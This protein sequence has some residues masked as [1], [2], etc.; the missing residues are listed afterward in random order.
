MMEP[1]SSKPL[2][3]GRLEAMIEAVEPAARLVERRWLRRI[4]R[5]HREMPVAAGPAPHELAYWI[6]REELLALVTP[7]ELGLTTERVPQGFV[8]LLPAPD[9]EELTPQTTSLTLRRYQ[10]AI[11]HARLDRDIDRGFADGFLTDAT[12]RNCFAQLGPTTLHEIR[13]LLDEEELLFN[14]EDDRSLYREFVAYFFSL[15]S[16]EPERLRDFLPGLWDPEATARE[17]Q[18]HIDAAAILDATRFPEAILRAQPAEAGIVPQQGSDTSAA[19]RDRQRWIRRA[20]DAARRG[21][22]VRAAFYYLRAG[23]PASAEERLDHLVERLQAALQLEDPARWRHALRPLLDR[24]AA[25]DWPV[26]ARLLYDL[27]KACIDSERPLYAVDVIEWAV[28]LGKKPIQRRLDRAREINLLRHL[29]AAARHIGGLPLR[30]EQQ[31]HLEALLHEEI[32]AAEHRARSELSPI[33]H[34]VLDDVGLR[35]TNLPEEI[36][37]NKATEE[38]LDQAC[39]RGFL[40]M[41]D[42][43]DALARNRL[44]LPDLSGPVEWLRGDPLIRA[45]RLLALR[46]D[47]VYHRGEI[48]LRWL[49]R[50]SALAF[51]TRVG[52]FVTRYLALPFGGAFVVLEGV[53]HLYHAAVGAAHFFTGRTAALRA[54]DAI[55]GPA[56]GAYARHTHHGSFTL[57]TW[58]AVLVLGIFLIGL[59]NLPRF[60]RGVGRLLR[61]ALIDVPTAI[62]RSQLVRGLFDNPLTRLFQ[63]YLFVPILSAG[64]GV[65]AARLFG[66][67]MQDAFMVGGAAAALTGIVFRTAIGR[68]AEERLNEALAYFWRIVSVNLIAGLFRLILDFFRK[69]LELIERGIYTVDER[70]RFREGEGWLSYW[71]KLTF[72]FVWFWLTYVL[73]FCVN[74]LIEPQINP[75]KHFPVVTVSHKLLLPLIPSL[76]SSFGAS[77]ETTTLIVSGIPGI[78]GFL[79][80]ELKENWKLYRA[81]RSPTL[82]PIPVG[83]HGERV[84]GLLRPGFHSG[85]VPKTFAKL[86]KALR[87]GRDRRA[88]KLRHALHHI[89]ENL[90]HF[91]ERDFLAYLQA[92]R[93]WGGVPVHL[94]AVTL[95]PRRVRLLLRTAEKTEVTVIAL[96]ERAGWLFAAIEQPG[97]LPRLEPRQQAA[98]TDSLTGLYALAG[99]DVVREQ[100]A[101][102][103]GPAGY[104]CDAE[105][106]GLIVSEP[107][108]QPIV[109]RFARGSLSAG[110]R[111][112]PSNQLLLSERSVSWDE[113]VERW[114]Q[115]QLGKT[116]SE[117]LVPDYRMLPVG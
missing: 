16:F 79:V 67:S 51:G 5:R 105:S 114:E 72:G 21:N 107:D 37:R 23:E 29:R 22:D 111:A 92:S 36:G 41:G 93:R 39:A 62:F 27:Q 12:V 66:A 78:F 35:P 54:I 30:P 84:R 74:L 25:D 47:G 31:H 89:V 32:E 85:V 64:L 63:R 38:L 115:D 71:F 14:S 58:P 9:L 48:Y 100:A 97:W 42:L 88:H 26:S 1:P 45:N 83:S 3:I 101:A 94:A 110:G 11:F 34:K 53:Q 49:Q 86:R 61:G 87:A 57:A 96:G 52:R 15:Y 108:A 8:L 13:V 50:L 60:R 59:L 28:T 69:V 2:D 116:P 18:R 33:V 82:N 117:P 17:L 77:I 70:L 65:L 103:F 19:P 20:Q 95:S 24:E 81:N 112:L 99:I 46:L 10:A 104:N 56:A 55:A 98:F 73:R 113:W 44:K 4:I 76:A 80:W 40:R 106:N 43:R 90:Q 102:I 91:A 75:I 109:Y 6:D 7:T 68:A